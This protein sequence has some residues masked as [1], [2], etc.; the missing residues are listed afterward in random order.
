[1]T[2]GRDNNQELT[3]TASITR[4]SRVKPCLLAQFAK[5]PFQITNY[6][7]FQNQ[8]SNSKLFPI[9]QNLL[10]LISF[11]IQL[12]RFAKLF[13]SNSIFLLAFPF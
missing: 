12:S 11:S 6:F 2:G 1:M 5:I 9:F 13:I 7:N 8:I 3:T 4:K 10:F